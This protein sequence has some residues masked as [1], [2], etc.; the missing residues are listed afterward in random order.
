MS[1]C[2]RPCVRYDNSKSVLAL[3]FFLVFQSLTSQSATAACKKYY[4][5]GGLDFAP[6]STPGA[7]C[8]G[9]W[10]GYE[11]P[12]VGVSSESQTFLA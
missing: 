3:L 8:A 7:A 11:S 12:I 9:A 1:S 5:T 6:S 2:Q 10:A 4:I